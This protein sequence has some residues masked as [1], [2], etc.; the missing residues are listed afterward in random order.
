MYDEGMKAWGDLPKNTWTVCGLGAIQH[1]EIADHT[2]KRIFWTRRQR[3]RAWISR[4]RLSTD[5]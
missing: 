3:L 4:M 5:S 1:E 2:F